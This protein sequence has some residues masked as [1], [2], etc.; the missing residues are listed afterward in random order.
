MSLT[1]YLTE[2]DAIY[3]ADPLGQWQGHRAAAIVGEVSDLMARAGHGELVR[4]PVPDVDVTAAKCYVAHCIAA[5][6]EKPTEPDA[7]TP[8][9]VAKRLGVTPETV[10]GWIKSGQLKAS[11]VGK[12]VAKPRYKI[13]P[14]NLERFMASRQSESPTPR[15]TA[16]KSS[17]KNYRS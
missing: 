15:T 12:G 16:R 13:Q 11:N 6:A 4:A 3:E 2:L 1:K 10:I 8:P 14:A 17:T 5:T 7:L 9:E